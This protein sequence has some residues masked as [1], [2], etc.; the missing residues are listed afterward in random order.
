[1]YVRATL[2]EI[3]QRQLNDCVVFEAFRCVIAQQFYIVVKSQK[4]FVGRVVN[5]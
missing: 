1:M 4:S 3:E 5:E 2:L